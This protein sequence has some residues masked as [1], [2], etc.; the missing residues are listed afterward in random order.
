MEISP[1]LRTAV[2]TGA[3]AGI[4]RALAARLHAEGVGLVVSDLDPDTCAATAAELDALS[5]P[6]DAADPTQV[7][8]LTLFATD[9]LGSL[10]A[11]FANAGVA[12]A[13]FVDDCVQPVDWRRA[14]DVNVMSHV[15]AFESVL[16]DWLAAGH[17]RFVSTVSAAGL[18][19]MLGAPA[20][21]ASKHA[22]VAFAEWISYTYGDRGIVAQCIC[23]LGVNTG[24]VE[25]DTP[26]AQ[27]LLRPGMLEPEAVADAVVQALPD[28]KFLILPHAKV[29]AAT[30]Q[31]AQDPD[32][33][34]AAM[35]GLQR[36]A[37]ALR[38]AS[39]EGDR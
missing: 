15:Y 8:A 38:S 37:D 25:W 11:F 10:D 28:N 3:G 33:W 19:A 31:R 27:L 17:G 30:V 26:E 23:P 12:S 5:F 16:P 4:G 36:K 21:N 13:G 32:A 1:P 39:A 2:V 20:Y 24:L 18:L 14:W 6:A 29:A 22:A 7:R 9:A 34:L 35:R